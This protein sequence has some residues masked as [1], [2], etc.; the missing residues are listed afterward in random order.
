M[1]AKNSSC[2]RLVPPFVWPDLAAGSFLHLIDSNE[3]KRGSKDIVYVF[4]LYTEAELSLKI[5][6]LL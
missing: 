5:S 6:G 3:V 2:S 1:H 4:I